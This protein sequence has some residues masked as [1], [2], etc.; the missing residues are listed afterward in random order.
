MTVPAR[1]FQPPGR[2]PGEGGL[3]L[4]GV[5]VLEF[6]HVASAPFAGMCLADLG[7][8]V[9][10]VEGPAGDQMRVWPPVATGSDGERFSHNF[11]AVNRN[12]RSIVADLKDPAWLASMQELCSH[13]DVVLENMR[14]GVLDR[15]GLGFETLSAGHRG[16]IYC[17]ISGYG[18]GSPY[19]GR[20]AYDVV[21]QAMSGLMSITGEPGGAPVKCGVPV[22]VFTAGLYAAVTICALL[23]QV[24]QSGES[25]RLDCPMLDCLIAVSALQTSEFW[26]TGR[27][28]Q[29]LGSR[30]PRNAPYQAFQ[31]SDG[32]FV[33]AAGNDRLFAEVCTVA[34]LPDLAT[35]A[36][37]ATQADRAA[38][39]LELAGILAGVFVI[40]PTAHWLDRLQSRGVPCGPVNT[41][42]QMLGDDHMTATGLLG[43]LD[44]PVAGR[45]P[46]V[47]YPVRISG[48]PP[49]LDRPAPRLGAD[50]DNVLREWRKS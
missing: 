4:H 28:P 9:V 25:R 18:P 1:A 44:L 16:L 6:G 15:L 23:P 49:R 2:N 10:K 3:P 8:D 45:T 13:A 37:F 7:A 41:Y 36:R 21:I 34:G 20:G 19:A 33:L 35:D 14:P 38:N 5:R 11:A 26:G 46:A 12:K 27:D 24:R 43:E 29:P 30:H 22:A 47:A 39:Q 32:P 17:S 31:A 50:T 42:A 40:G 48:T